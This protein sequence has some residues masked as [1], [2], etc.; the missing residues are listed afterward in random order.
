MLFVALGDKEAELEQNRKGLEIQ[1]ALVAAEPG[2]TNTRRELAVALGNTGSNLRSLNQ[3]AAAL[4]LFHEALGHYEALV[5]ADPKDIFIR[6]Q[7]AVANRNVAVA[8]GADDPAEALRLFQKATGIL[9]EIVTIDPNNTDF[10]RQW[11]FTYMATGRF[12]NDINEFEQAV[13]SLAEGI[14]IEEALVRD[15]PADVSVHTTLALLYN[16]LGLTQ[17][18]WAAKSDLPKAESNEHW[19]GAKRLTPKASPSTKG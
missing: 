19:S 10:R 7:W 17:A 1:R 15:S 9:A 12:Q 4:P 6:R 13:A 8:V 11:A 5:A 16:Q 18:K 3:K 14:R 2:N